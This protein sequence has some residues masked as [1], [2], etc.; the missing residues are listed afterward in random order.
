MDAT[1]PKAAAGTAPIRIVRLPERYAALGVAVHFLARRKTFDRFPFS[2]LVA[3]IDGQITRGHY[4][5]AFQGNRLI[6]Y[7]GYA[8]YGTADAEAFAM[9]GRLPPADQASGADVVWLLTLAA[10]EDAA[11]EAFKKRIKADFA[12]KRAMGVRH[13]ADGSRH[14]FDFRLRPTRSG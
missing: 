11:V 2:E 6:G 7:V 5:F 1:S 8:L 9:T 4:H 12:G 14:A 3:T 13:R 10:V